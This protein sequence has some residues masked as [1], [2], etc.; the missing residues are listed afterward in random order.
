MKMKRRIKMKTGNT[1]SL[2][3]IMQETYNGA[4]DLILDTQKTINELKSAAKPDDVQEL[5]IVAK[6]TTSALKIKENAIKIKLEL[7]KIQADIIKHNGDLREGI[8][9][10]S[11]GEASIDDFKSVREMLKNKGTEEESGADRPYKL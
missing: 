3:Q 9:E 6:E 11:K 7:V 5:G 1:D 8:A 2:E 4:C 10:Y